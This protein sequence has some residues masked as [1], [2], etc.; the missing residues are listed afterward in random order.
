MIH[1]GGRE[2]EDNSYNCLQPFGVKSEKSDIFLLELLWLVYKFYILIMLQSCNCVCDSRRRHALTASEKLCSSSFLFLFLMDDVV[3]LN[4]ARSTLAFAEEGGKKMGKHC[5]KNT[6][7]QLL[8]S[9][10]EQPRPQVGR[11]REKV[12]VHNLHE[13]R[14][15]LRG[16]QA[17]G[18]NCSE[19]WRDDYVKKEM[20]DSVRH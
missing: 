16:E 1:E 20:R 7:I 6:I 3:E 19:N 18:S 8:M 4:R 11:E 15:R 17:S 14:N 10:V 2:K 9:R 5:G 13:T 12:Q